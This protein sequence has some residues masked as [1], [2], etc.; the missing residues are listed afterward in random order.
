MR[1]LTK[2]EI[3]FTVSTESE[4]TQVRGNCMA[5][6]DPVA[7]KQAEDEIIDRLN[8]GDESAW[9]VVVLT[10]QWEEFKVSSY[11]GACSFA[12]GLNGAECAKQAVEMVKDF[13]DEL[14]EELN[15]EILAAIE[16][17]DQLHSIFDDN[18]LTK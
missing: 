17:G 5:T 8:R 12:E 7:D 18:D 14:V 6:D 2:K 3:T 4:D 15:K 9:C 11:L 1:Q 10:A 13:K 16:R